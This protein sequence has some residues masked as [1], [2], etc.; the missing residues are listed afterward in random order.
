MELVAI[1]ILLAL[2]EYNIF[3]ILVG[4]ARAKYNVPAP[5]TS[6][7]PVFERYCRVHQN[8][9]EQLMVFYTGHSGIWILRQS[10]HRR[11]CRT[12]VH[13]GPHHIPAGLCE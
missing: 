7:D 10:D 4:R 1:V 3:G 12:G 5:A 13:R 2:I 6:G 8:T 9:L 11:A